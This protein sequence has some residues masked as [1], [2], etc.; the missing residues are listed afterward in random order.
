MT[1]FI[2]AQKVVKYLG[3]F[4]KKIICDKDLSKVAQTGHTGLA[5]VSQEIFKDKKFINKLG[6]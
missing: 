4:W 6:P 1:F 3:Y 5:N 2:I